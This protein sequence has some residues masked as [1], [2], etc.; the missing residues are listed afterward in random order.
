MTVGPTSVVY[1]GCACT[2]KLVEIH[3]KHTYKKENQG[4]GLEI[5]ERKTLVKHPKYF[6]KKPQKYL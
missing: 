2:Q 1:F 4:I 5:E 3:N 6:F